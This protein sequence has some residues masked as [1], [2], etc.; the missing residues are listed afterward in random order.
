VEQSIKALKL[1]L[2]D[3]QRNQPDSPVHV[4][5]ETV[6]RS[7]GQ[8]SSAATPTMVSAMRENLDK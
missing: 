7:D 8:N 4:L 1:A 2:Q 6:M 3:A 5:L